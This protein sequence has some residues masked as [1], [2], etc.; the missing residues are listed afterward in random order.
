MRT[1][2]APELSGRGAFFHDAFPAASFEAERHRAGVL[3]VAIVGMMIVPLPTLLLDLLIGVNM[4]LV[5]DP[6]AGRDLRADALKLSAFPTLLLITTLFRLALRSATTRLI[7]LTGDAGQVIDA[8]GNFVVRGN[9]VVGASSSSSSRSST[10][11]SSRR[12]SERVAEV[13]ARFTLDAMPGKQM[14]IDAD[15]R[16][17]A[18]D[19]DEAQAPAPRRSS[20][21][22]SSS[23]RWTAR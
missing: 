15:L 5:G 22:A 6:A 7:L 19:L 21:R 23:A 3:V 8:F 18:I 17:G 13:A 2:R 20:A 14:S 9:F 4:T 10:S 16:A 12:A 11:S 1:V